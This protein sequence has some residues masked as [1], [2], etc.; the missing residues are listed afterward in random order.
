MHS[1]F[2]TLRQRVIDH[3]E[4]LSEF[5]EDVG[6]EGLELAHKLLA[7]NAPSLIAVL[8]NPDSGKSDLIAKLAGVDH[9]TF[10]VG[11]QSEYRFLHHE[12]SSPS[13][14]F[15]PADSAYL[16]AKSDYL[17]KLTFVEF[18]YKDEVGSIVEDE[19]ISVTEGIVF[20]LDALDPWS[21]LFWRHFENYIESHK[22]RILV[23]V[24]NIDKLDAKDWPILQ[25][26]IEDKVSQVTLNITSI[27]P[28]DFEDLFSFQQIR[29]F[30]EAEAV[31]ERKWDE[32]TH[33]C[34]YYKQAYDQIEDT[35]KEQENWLHGA[36][37]VSRGM[38]DSFL[39][40]RKRISLEL[41]QR[42]NVIGS[43]IVGRAGEILGEVRK[44][45]SHTLYLKSLIGDQNSLN[46]FQKS[47]ET[48]LTDALYSEI[49]QHYR[50]AN[51]VVE[52]HASSF[53]NEYPQYASKCP[54]LS[55]DESGFKLSFALEREEVDHAIRKVLRQLRLKPLFRQELKQID[56]LTNIRLRLAMVLLM[57][58]G[59]FGI[60]SIHLV[61]F[62]FFGVA[63]G[64]M[65]WAF[66]HRKNSLNQFFDFLN[67]WFLGIGSRVQEPFESLS[68]GLVEG[69]I[70]DYI[71][72]FTPFSNAVHESESR[73]PD[74]VEK[75]RAL[76]V[77][78]RELIKELEY[79]IE[80]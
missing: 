27:I 11:K 66:I 77:K 59:I 52:E 5:A 9:E 43:S 74:T 35:V 73:V 72:S 41:S 33:L 63:L 14:Q 37:N 21:G 36:Q 17:K 47:L 49:E 15:L 68:Y 19:L 22:G 53:V 70:K 40:L 38:D 31:S 26:F 78:N 48:I 80:S 39:E 23:C 60:F 54:R 58:A 28:L 18:R 42:I 25:T 3:G 24:S 56:D 76:Y 8:G 46:S 7:L 32:L 57:G 69:A 34:E 62:I 6:A 29:T 61:A 44:N 67:E 79:A 65:S 10:D 1:N 13:R 30:L 64:I 20:V 51:E 45:L 55:N 71:D 2:H 16:G 50:K 75:T 12:D 4:E